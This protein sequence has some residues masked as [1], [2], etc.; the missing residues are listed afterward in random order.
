MA[1]LE[2]LTI[3]IDSNIRSILSEYKK[4]T[5]KSHSEIVREAIKNYFSNNGKKYDEGTT[6]LYQEMLAK[7]EH[8]ILDI[9]HW[10][11]FLKIVNGMGEGD[12]WK[13]HKAVAMSHGEQFLQSGLSA[14]DILRRLE[15]CNFFTLNAHSSRIFTLILTSEVTKGFIKTFI[16]EVF[17]EMGFK[18]EVKEDYSKLRVI[19]LDN[20]THPERNG[21]GKIVDAF[22][23]E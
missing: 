9:D 4:S 20:K 1:E 18:F 6:R 10:I 7:G 2:R 16:E 11:L 13:D 19:I 21:K 5:G 15:V 14:M 22:S 23:K 17:N 12:F 8:V 3:S